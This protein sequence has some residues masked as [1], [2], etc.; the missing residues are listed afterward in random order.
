MIIFGSAIGENKFSIF[1]V[2][3]DFNAKLNELSKGKEY[4][5]FDVNELGISNSEKIKEVVA[6][7]E[8]DTFLISTKDAKLKKIN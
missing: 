7:R 1:D 3:D 2:S 5:I 4:L 8:I 6:F